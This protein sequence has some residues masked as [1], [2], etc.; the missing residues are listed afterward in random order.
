MFNTKLFPII[1]APVTR[2]GNLQTTITP[3]EL[4]G[5][6]TKIDQTFRADYVFSYGTLRLGG[7]NWEWSLMEWGKYL[8]TFRLPGFQYRG[9]LSTVYTGN[10]ESFAVVDLF[11]I[12][13]EFTDEAN[14]DLDDLESIPAQ[15]D[16]YYRVMAVPFKHPVTGEDIV[17]KMYPTESAEDFFLPEGDYLHGS[18]LDTPRMQDAIRKEE[19]GNKFTEFYNLELVGA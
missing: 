5:D 6:V 19:F 14:R 11:Q 8:G 4:G 7:G 3:E 10:P 2:K 16:G 15:W 1:D 13:E 9:G 12:K 18:K 17:V